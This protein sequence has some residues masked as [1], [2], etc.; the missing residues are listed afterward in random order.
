MPQSQQIMLIV[1]IILALDALI[2]WALLRALRVMAW[3][4]MQASHPPREV[5]EPSVARNFQSFSFD[6]FNMGWCVHVVV[7]EQCLHLRPS[8]FLRL[9]GCGPMSI[10]WEAIELKSKPGRWP[11]MRAKVGKVEVQGPKWCMRLADRST[12]PPDQG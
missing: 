12:P 4:P 9:I 3:G 10:P 5:V 7:D 8:A 1:A 11:F 6:W 2:V